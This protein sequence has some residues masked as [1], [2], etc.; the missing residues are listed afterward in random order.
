MAPDGYC[1]AGQFSGSVL[2]ALMKLGESGAIA[3]AEKFGADAWEK[4]KP[5]WGKLRPRV[6]AKPLAQGR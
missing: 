5:L 4:A 2:S 3:V 6:E 1:C